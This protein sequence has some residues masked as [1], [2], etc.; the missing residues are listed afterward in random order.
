[1]FAQHRGGG[2]LLARVLNRHPDVVIWGEHGGFINQLAEADAV[3]RQYAGTMLPRQEA[4]FARF[5]SREA[6]ADANFDPWLSPIVSPDIAACARATIL[7]L[8]TRRVRQGQRWGFKEI[9]YHRPLVARFL[10]R[11][12]PACRIV[13]L[14]RDPAELCVSAILA[15]WSLDS[16][17]ARGARHDVVEVMRIVEDC[18]YAAVAMQANMAT[19]AND[20]PANTFAVTYEAFTASP[21]TGIDV[22]LSFLVLEAAPPVRAAMLATAAAVAGATDKQPP[23]ARGAADLPLLNAE[24]IRAVAASLLP[25]IRADIAGNGI[26]IARLRRLAGRGEYSFLMG[27]APAI[28]PGCS[29][30]F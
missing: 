17:R 27:D 12:F 16:L 9:R 3:A 24:L 1:V 4:V 22:L 28:E 29:A 25:R 19:I 6:V 13:L 23:A 21:A 15:P 30:I 10:A 18:L 14:T 2:T 26:D 20:L 11:L 5:L 7:D 8:F